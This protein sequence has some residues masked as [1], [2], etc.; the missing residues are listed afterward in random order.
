MVLHST[1]TIKPTRE[2]PGSPF[3]SMEINTVVHVGLE[4]G[5]GNSDGGQADISTRAEQT[6]ADATDLEVS[7]PTLLYVAPEPGPGNSEGGG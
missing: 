2:S 4:P 3:L 5:P 1:P 7:V 6:H